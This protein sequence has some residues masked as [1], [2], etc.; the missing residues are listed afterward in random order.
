LICHD[1][2]TLLFQINLSYVLR[3]WKVGRSAYFRTGSRMNAGLIIKNVTKEWPI[4][5]KWTLNQCLVKYCH[6]N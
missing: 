5:Y 6:A 2:N 1:I 4:Y 3:H